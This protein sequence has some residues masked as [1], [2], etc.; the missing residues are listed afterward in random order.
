MNCEWLSCAGLVRVCEPKVKH[1][2]KIKCGWLSNL[3][4]CDF[5]SCTR[6]QCGAGSEQANIRQTRIGIAAVNRRRVPCTNRNSRAFAREFPNL[7][8]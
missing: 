2:L 3:F 4:D 1:G 8:N 7:T 6:N 5:G